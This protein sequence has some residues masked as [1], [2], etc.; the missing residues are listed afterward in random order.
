VP[1]VSA[2]ACG[3]VAGM[4]DGRVTGSIALANPYD[5]RA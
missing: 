3:A 1:G 2:G 4:S 5:P